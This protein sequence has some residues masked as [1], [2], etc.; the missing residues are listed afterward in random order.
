MPQHSTHIEELIIKYARGKRLSKREMSDL[1]QWQARSADHRALPEKFRDVDWLRENLRR[2]EKVPSDRMWDFIRDRIALDVQNES[3]RT[4]GHLRRL[5]QWAPFAAAGLL[6]AVGWWAV[7]RPAVG[8]PHSELPVPVIARAGT[9]SDGAVSHQVLLTLGDGR[10][11]PLDRVPNGVIAQLGGLVLT[12][13]DS[14]RIEYS[15]MGG[16]ESGDGESAMNTRITTG[17]TAPFHLVFPD[18]STVALSH[19]SSLATSFHKGQREVRLAGEALFKTAKN[20]HAPFTVYTQKMQVQVLGTA[21]DVSS[22][23]DEPTGAVSLLSGAVRVTNKGE[24][25]LLKPLQQALV[26]DGHVAV[27]VLRDSAAVLAWADKNPCFRFDNADLNTVVR[28]IARWHQVTVHNPN[29]ITGIP[30]TGIFRQNESLEVLL[31]MIDRVESGSAY[32]KRKGDTIEVSGA[33]A[34]R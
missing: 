5:R 15:V 11:I 2:L 8:H 29:N 1:E 32:L 17:R 4:P 33:V 28:R 14:N 21:F 20:T 26:T 24:A 23:D 16:G 13:T 7:D 25:A 34:S 18:G 9:I 30:I 12:K 3:R 10:V 19:A 31:G 22:Y 6:L 27:R